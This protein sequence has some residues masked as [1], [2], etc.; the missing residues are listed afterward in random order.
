MPVPIPAG[1][2]EG[3][4]PTCEFENDEL[5]KPLSQG[6]IQKALILKIKFIL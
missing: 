3:L 1:L 5:K 4:P 6:V 2:R